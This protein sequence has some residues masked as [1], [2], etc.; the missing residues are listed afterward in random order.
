MDGIVQ[1]VADNLNC[2]IPICSQPN[3]QLFQVNNCNHHFHL[4]CL[5]ENLEKVRLNYS[6]G[7]E[8]SHLDSSYC[9]QPSVSFELNQVLSYN[10]SE[11]NRVWCPI[12]CSCDP[13]RS[14]INMH[15]TAEQ[16]DTLATQ[17]LSI[18]DTNIKRTAQSVIN[19]RRDSS[20]TEAVITDLEDN[21]RSSLIQF[22][23]NDQTGVEQA[24]NMH[25]TILEC[26]AIIDPLT[27][28][29]RNY[30]YVSSDARSHNQFPSEQE[31]FLVGYTNELI[32]NENRRLNTLEALRF[33]LENFCVPELFDMIN[34]IHLFSTNHKIALLYFKLIESSLSEEEKVQIQVLELTDQY[35][36]DITSNARAYQNEE[37]RISLNQ[38]I[39]DAYLSHASIL[40]TEIQDGEVAFEPISY[41]GVDCL[42]ER[43]AYLNARFSHNVAVSTH[44]KTL[45]EAEN[46]IDLQAY[47]LQYADQ[48]DS[49]FASHNPNE[50]P[51]LPDETVAS[52]L[53]SRRDE[54]RIES[55][56]EVSFLL[57]A[58]ALPTENNSDFDPHRIADVT[59]EEDFRSGIP[60][61]PLSSPLTVVRSNH[62]ES[63]PTLL[64]NI[65]LAITPQDSEAS[66]MN[67][68][69][70]CASSC[71]SFFYN[72]ITWPYN[73]FFEA[74]E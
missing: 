27:K 59:S 67:W 34:D 29:V 22:L 37:E 65:P 2:E 54:S 52:I 58:E 12:C 45:V 73:Y 4:P 18:T 3:T 5:F 1:V 24:G 55:G 6:T 15:L 43:R 69:W 30:S 28:M 8:N 32:E 20:A 17:L 42:E 44:I 70:D 57:P 38:T 66:W 53:L 21:L 64:R 40:Q 9:D 72:M 39:N 25:T 19:W 26:S 7:E 51:P 46:H 31:R 47:I 14:T 74:S 49:Y 61:R 50:T 36:K 63:T 68:I 13:N 35:I 16:I 41:G 10:A 11:P 71:F 33:E 56:A 62:M 60:N 23:Q 48:A